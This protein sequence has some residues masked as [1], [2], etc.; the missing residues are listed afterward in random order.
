MRC[1]VRIPFEIKDAWVVKYYI[2]QNTHR[3]D[4]DGL[5]IVQSAKDKLGEILTSYMKKTIFDPWCM[6]L[7]STP[8]IRIALPSNYNRFGLTSGDLKAISQILKKIAQDDL[9]QMV[10][11]YASLPGVNREQVIRALWKLIGLTDDD[12]DMEHFRRYFDRY[13]Q[14]STGTSFLNFQNE[15]TRALKPI[16]DEKV[17]AS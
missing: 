5:T 1:L 15:V 6:A 4:A 14:N 2:W 7:P 16:Y 3:L 12:Y 17:L 11:I 9:C 8:H 10:M 13:G